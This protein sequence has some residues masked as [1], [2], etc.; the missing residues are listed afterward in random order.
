MTELI[1][2]RGPFK[3]GAR[4]PQ[5]KA[6]ELSCQSHG[7]SAALLLLFTWTTTIAQDAPPLIPFQGHLARPSGEDVSQFDPVPNGQ[8]DILFTLYAAPVGGESKVWGPERHSNVIIVNGLVNAMLGS[9]IGFNDV[10]A[11]NPIFFARPLYVGITVDADGNPNTADL[12]LIP[13]QVLLPAVQAHNASRLDG[14]DWRDFFAGTDERGTFVEGNTRARDAEKLD[15]ADWTRFFAGT[16]NNATFL[17][18]ETKARNADLLDGLDSSAFARTTGVIPIGSIIA[19]YI[20]IEGAADLNHIREAGFALCD[21][22]TAESQGIL[23]PTITAALPNL[24]GEGRYLRGANPGD[25]GNLQDDATSRN[26]LEATVTDPGHEHLT[27]IA[28]FPN[29]DNIETGGFK[30]TRFNGMAVS[31]QDVMRDSGHYNTQSSEA[32]V[33]VELTNG[34]PETRPIT[35]TVVWIMRVK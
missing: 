34:D 28:D 26:G 31:W 7:W 4:R 17:E 15:G 20:D 30:T 11:A 27:P 16:D 5:M 6:K 10:I 21:G 18:G 33:T 19:H 25:T 12:E 24:N 9:V 29:Q 1:P 8:Y 13:R 2:S 35:M 14:A 3:A 32:N 22:S 23:E